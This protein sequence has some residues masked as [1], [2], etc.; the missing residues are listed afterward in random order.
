VGF[1]VGDGVLTSSHVA[2]QASQRYSV[3]SR[4]KPTLVAVAVVRGDVQSGHVIL[5]L[6]WF[7]RNNKCTNISRYAGFPLTP[8]SI[9]DGQTPEH[10]VFG[11]LECTRSRGPSRR[12]QNRAPSDCLRRR[13]S[14][15]LAV[16]EL[17]MVRSDS[18]P[19]FA[20]RTGRGEF[21]SSAINSNKCP[22][23]ALKNTAAA[24]IQP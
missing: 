23:G 19:P 1:S 11:A 13:S 8:K 9:S 18:A 10:W 7:R 16:S 5:P 17:R 24:G 21:D 4:V 20:Q 6:C 3:S 12:P 14:S 22:L 15:Q 2:E